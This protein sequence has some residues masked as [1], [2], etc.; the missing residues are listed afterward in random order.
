MIMFCA[1]LCTTVVYS[2]MD[3]HMRKFCSLGLLFSLVY[4]VLLF[5]VF[6][7]SGLSVFSR[8]MTSY[9]ATP[10][11]FIILD[12]DNLCDLLYQRSGSVAERLACWT[13]A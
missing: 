12:Y 10:A 7:V 5:F 11:S 4:N 2:N 6:V 9:H 1:L 13:Q 3:M 8:P